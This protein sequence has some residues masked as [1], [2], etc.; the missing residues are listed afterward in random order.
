MHQKYSSQLEFQSRIEEDVVKEVAKKFC[1]KTL[2][3][4]RKLQPQ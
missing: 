4:L 1:Y 3:S 2:A